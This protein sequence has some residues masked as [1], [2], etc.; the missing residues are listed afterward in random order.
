MRIAMKEANETN[1]WC[2]LLLHSGMVTGEEGIGLVA[3]SEI[4]CRIIGK[5]I[6]TTQKKIEA[7][8][9]VSRESTKNQISG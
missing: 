5:I 4:I 8:V 6:S 7:N 9:S 3:E 2:S 1:Y